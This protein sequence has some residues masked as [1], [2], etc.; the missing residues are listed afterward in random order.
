MQ[1]SLA[2]RGLNRNHNHA[3]RNIFKGAVTLAAATPGPFQKFY[4]AC[5]ARRVKL[6][7]PRLALARKIVSITSLVRKK[8]YVST[9]NIR[10]NK[11]LERLVESFSFSDSLLAMISVLPLRG[12]VSICAGIESR[13]RGHRQMNLQ[14][15]EARAPTL[16]VAL[17]RRQGAAKAQPAEEHLPVA[18]QS[19]FERAGR[20]ERTAQCP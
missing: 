1:K 4:E 20:S 9:P 16:F 18:D 12:R 3:S 5:P 15:E 11:Q 13:T 10:N 8:E 14:K 6:S 19:T 7:M 17:L 2:I